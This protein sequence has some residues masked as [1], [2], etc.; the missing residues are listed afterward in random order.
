LQKPVGVNVDPE[1]EAVPHDVAVGAFWQL[2][3]PSHA[4]V[5]PQG[6]EA[7]QRPCGSACDGGTKVH[8]PAL[9]A[10]LQAWQVPQ[11]DV[12]QHTPSTQKFPERQSSVDMQV[13]PRRFLSPQ[14]FVLTSQMLGAVQPVSATH[15]VPQ[16]VPL[17]AKGAHGSVLAGRQVPA[18]SQVR[19]RVCVV[20]PR[21]HDA[22]AQVVPAA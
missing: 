6:G 12:A 13:C 22:G 17:H 18:P 1:H 14:R 10:T 5:K 21:G 20:E 15:V 3:A 19:A 8:A 4:P 16:V 2:P 7:V 11:A 9:P